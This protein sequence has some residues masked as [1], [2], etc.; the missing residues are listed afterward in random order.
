M[1]TTLD[2]LKL[3]ERSVEE[4]HPLVRDIVRFVF[5]ATS[6]RC[7]KCF[8]RSDDC[9]V[10][11]GSLDMMKVDLLCPKATCLTCN[12]VPQRGQEFSR[13]GGQAKADKLVSGLFDCCHELGTVAVCLG[14]HHT[15]V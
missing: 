13:V 8:A 10:V 5:G 7:S 1:I 9:V 15:Y 3:G 11:L 12:F 14:R 6:T 4:V 2:N